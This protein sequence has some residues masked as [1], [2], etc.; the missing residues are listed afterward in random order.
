MT[1]VPDYPPARH[2]LRDLRLDVE[3]HSDGSSTAWLPVVPDLLDDHGGVRTGALATLVDVIGGGLAA[4]A[5]RP[6]WIAT[7]D[8]TLHLVDD[9]RAGTVRAR[10][11]VLRAG[12]TTVVLEVAL[13]TEQAHGGA[14][15]TLGLATMTFGVLPRRDGNPV[16]SDDA[17]RSRSTLALADSGFRRPFIDAVG[18]RLAERGERRAT[19]ELQPDDYI[20]NSLGAVQGGIVAT[21][22]ESAAREAL[23]DACGAPVV[24]R[25]L[26]VTYLALARVG[27]V[28]ATATALFATPRGSTRPFGTAAVDV[29]DAGNEARLT[30]TA[31]VVAALPAGAPT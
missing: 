19:V 5:A 17:S 8:L 27:P 25:D 7:A 28:R 2:L 23:R 3:H 24:A 4:H 21:L 30:T 6:D 15:A 16:I 12:R 11:R 18:V 20:R 29:V 1:L 31:R 13:A 10:A 22:V 26:Q 14:G 9:A